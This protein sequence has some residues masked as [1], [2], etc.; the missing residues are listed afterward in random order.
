MMVLQ[1]DGQAPT[2]ISLLLPK[3]SSLWYCHWLCGIS[4]SCYQAWDWQAVLRY[5]VNRC[6]EVTPQLLCGKW[7][8]VSGRLWILAAEVA[9][10]RPGVTSEWD[11][12][13]GGWEHRSQESR[14]LRY[15][16]QSLGWTVL[17][18]IRLAES[19]VGDWEARRRKSCLECSQA[20]VM[21]WGLS[22]QYFGTVRKLICQANEG[23][24][25]LIFFIF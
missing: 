14:Q 23:L 4:G 13:G 1:P 25:K 18:R 10:W 19:G 8:A 16:A 20:P 21:V 15:P 6:S 17:Q 9:W 3:A 22:K 24:M 7:E 11:V 12:D 2:P 5:L